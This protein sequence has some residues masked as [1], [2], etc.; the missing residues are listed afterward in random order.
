MTWRHVLERDL[1]SVF[2]ARTGASV[3]SFTLLLMVLPMWIISPPGDAIIFLAVLT[4]LTVVL[5]LVLAFLGRPLLVTLVAAV[6]TA[7]FLVIAITSP[8]DGVGQTEA[9]ATLL[10]LIGGGLGFLVPVV[11][12]LGSYGALVGERSTGSIR[13]L[14]GLPNS[15]GDAYA[16]KFLSRF[17]VVAV[18]VSVGVV[19]IG[20]VGL[21]HLGAGALVRLLAL[22]LLTVPYIVVFVGVGLAASARAE[23][24]SHAVGMAVGVFVLLQV[25]WPAI[26]GLL[27]S[28]TE[29]AFA[30]SPLFFWFDRVNPINAYGKAR[31]LLSA[32]NAD[33]LGGFLGVG[34]DQV[35]APIAQSGYFALAVLL[36]WAVVTPL[37]GY[38]VFANRDAL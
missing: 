25:G 5:L 1:R 10:G 3:L 30:R 8:G 31:S 26:E 15:R 2:R 35:V 38:W 7:V 19:L 12:L 36:F 9:L 21:A 37:V 16:G 33:V 6:F 23:T 20:V 24:E 22:G 4:L 14:L 17:G 27:I 28:L 11:S 34:T 32:S 13:F 18:A 29:G